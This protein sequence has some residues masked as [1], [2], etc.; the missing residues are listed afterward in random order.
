MFWLNI[1]QVAGG[2]EE[3]FLSVLLPRVG[4]VL[5]ILLYSLS[6]LF[7]SLCLLASCPHDYIRGSHHPSLI[8]LTCSVVET[9]QSNAQLLLDSGPPLSL[10]CQEIISETCIPVPVLNWQ[11]GSL[12]V[13]P[14][15]TT[16][17]LECV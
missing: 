14:T 6:S 13:T 4:A 12:R 1:L 2:L 15:T 16:T 3:R 7:L 11:E 8:H 5:H 10:R 9:V 17:T